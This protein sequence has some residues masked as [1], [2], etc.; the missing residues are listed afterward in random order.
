MSRQRFMAKK[1]ILKGIVQGVGCRGYTA[2]YARIF[3]LK[4]SA[5]NLNNGTVRLL[6]DC[7]DD[8][9]NISLYQRP[10][11]KPKGIMFYG[12]ITDFEVNDYDGKINR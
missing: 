2:R 4:G 5:T 6:I 10:N 1:I 8:K 9:N 7:D 12:K 3:G 11:S